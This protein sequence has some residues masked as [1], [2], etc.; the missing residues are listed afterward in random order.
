VNEKQTSGS[1]FFWAFPSDS[2]P[3]AT[4]INVHSF[5]HSFPHAAIPVNNTSEFQELFEA[6]SWVFY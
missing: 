5:V 2:I 4:N 3:R 6:T 1:S